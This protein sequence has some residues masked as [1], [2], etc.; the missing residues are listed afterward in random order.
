M[1]VVQWALYTDRGRYLS[2]MSRKIR[3]GLEGRKEGMG[4]GRIGKI[5]VSWDS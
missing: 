5:Y 2:M 1:G 3:T 4:E